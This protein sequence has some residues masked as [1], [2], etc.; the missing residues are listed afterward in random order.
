M[1]KD[2]KPLTAVAYEYV[3]TNII[4]GVYS[5]N[6]IVSEGS[7]IQQLGISKTPVREALVALCTEGILQSIPRMG[8][9]VIQIMPS[10]ACQMYQARLLLESTLLK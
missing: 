9:Q 8:Y 5:V 2:K 7:L 4:N 10:E 3:Y 1:L 6:D